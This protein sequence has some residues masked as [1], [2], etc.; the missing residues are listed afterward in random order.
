[1]TK[2]EKLVLLTAIISGVSIFLNAFGVKGINPYIFTG[3]KNLLVGVLILSIILLIGNWNKIKNLS[4]KDWK[5]LTIIGLIGGSI[6]FLLFFKGLQLMAPSNASFIH[7]TMIV[8][9]SVLAIIFLKEKLDRKIVI[10]SLLILIGNF[11]LLKIISFEISTGLILVFLAAMFWSAEIILSKKALAKMDGNTVAFGRML[12]GTIFILAFLV[13]TGQTSGILALNSQQMIWILITS[14][15]L[16]GYVLTFYNGLKTVKASTAVAILSIGAVITSILNLIFLDHILTLLQISG[17]ILLVIGAITF[18][19][20][21][22]IW[23][24]VHSIFSIA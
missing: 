9:V 10:G 8:W 4:F 5:S 23:K 20:T 3:A 7:K 1:M 2:G 19:F 16:L 13:A 15:L 14:G 24:K 11:L 22:E 21:K 18:S 17:I 12:F 6:P